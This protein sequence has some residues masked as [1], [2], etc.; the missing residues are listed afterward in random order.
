[1]VTTHESKAHFSDFE[2]CITESL[3][4][5]S[6]NVI[7]TLH[8]NICGQEYIGQTD[9][10]FRLRF[11]NHR[12]HATSLPKLPLS[13][14]L[15]LPNHSFENISVTL[16]QSGFSN[17]REREQREAYFIFK[18]RT[19]VAGIKEDPGKLSCLREVSQEEIGDKD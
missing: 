2:F 16:L 12:Y 4:C 9:T 10:P 18:F 5:D 15:R 3:S 6:S 8:C 17:R 19:L 13:R 14:H 11:N 1:M 7:Y